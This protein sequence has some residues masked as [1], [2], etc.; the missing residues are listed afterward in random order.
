MI[1]LTMLVVL[2]QAPAADLA[3]G[4]T[5]FGQRC[6]M[7]H[8]ENGKG[9]GVVATSITPAPADLTAARFSV[10]RLEAVFREG[11]AG[12]AMPAQQDLTAFDRA[13]LIAFIQSIGPQ[14]PPAKSAVALLTRGQALFAIRCAACHG[15]EGDGRGPARLHMTRQPADFTR[16]QPTRARIDAVLERG[17]PGT[18]MTPIRRLLTADDVDALAAWLQHVYG[19]KLEIGVPPEAD[20]Q[21]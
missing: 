19:Q 4:K 18:A 10:D 9:D 7:C 5:L 8:G 6:S 3:R 15:I 21:P 11:V 17:I 16:K 13:A 1:A 14:L 12:A 2:A 20:R